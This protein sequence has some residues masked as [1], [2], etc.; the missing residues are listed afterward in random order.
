MIGPSRSSST[1]KRQATSSGGPLR[2]TETPVV[3]GAHAYDGEDASNTTLVNSGAAY[4]ITK[5]DTD[6]NGD[7]STDWTDWNSLNDDGW[8]GLT[9]KLTPT[10][11][12][13]Y[14]FFGGSVALDDS[15]LGDRVSPRRRWGAAE[16]WCGLCVHQ[17]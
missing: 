17:G 12:E 5:P 14:A 15:T 3:V 11:P 2:W 13:A 1:A 4:V 10:V 16:C 9:A 8:A 6:A 7:G